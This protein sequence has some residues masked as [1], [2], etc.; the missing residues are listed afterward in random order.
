M[1]I[2]DVLMNSIIAFMLEHEID[3]EALRIIL[4]KIKISVDNLEDVMV[5]LI[6]HYYKLKKNK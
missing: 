4:S 5:D 3:E 6:K 2:N 1:T